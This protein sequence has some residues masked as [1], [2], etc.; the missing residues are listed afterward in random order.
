MAR[1]TGEEARGL[2]TRVSDRWPKANTRSQVRQPQT[3]LSTAP[4]PPATQTPESQTPACT[5]APRTPATQASGRSL[6]LPAAQHP[7][8]SSGAG[9]TAQITTVTHHRAWRHHFRSPVQ[10]E[11][12]ALV[13]MLLRILGQ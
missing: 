5:L 2:H 3:P 11:N 6:R 10:D 4:P 7:Q 8:L 9:A 1:G 12:A 13:Q